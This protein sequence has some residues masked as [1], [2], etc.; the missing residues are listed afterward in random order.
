MADRG[1]QKMADSVKKYGLIADSACD[2][3]EE[4]VKTL[5]IEIVPFYISFG[6]ENYLKEGKELSV[7]SFYEKMKTAGGAY[8]KTSLPSVDDYMRVFEKFAGEKIPVICIC[9]SSELS[10]SYNSAV[11]AAELVKETYPDAEIN[12]IDSHLAT[13]L[14]GAMLIEAARMRRDGLSCGE[15]VKKLRKMMLTGRI[16]FS[17][18]TMD[19]LIHG[20][21]VGRLKGAVAST[22]GL[23]PILMFGQG[24]LVSKGVARNKKKAIS[25]LIELAADYFEKSQEDAA[26]YHIVTGYGEDRSGCDK[27]R[28]QLAGAFC[29]HGI[30]V[31]PVYRIGATIGVHVGPQTLGLGFIKKYEYV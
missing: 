30:K 8:P 18:G 5:G 29:G 6:N 11:N 1:I 7:Q 3:P 22:L 10:G 13:I 26:L 24:E 19:Y 28:E 20:G 15:C 14:Q 4:T 2:L 9:L 17:I 21:R 25:K 23:K 31:M 12:V 27:L 16:Y